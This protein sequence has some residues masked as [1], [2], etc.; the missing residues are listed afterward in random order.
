MVEQVAGQMVTGPCAEMKSG[1]P[2][3]TADYEDGA[4]YGQSKLANL[5]FARYKLTFL[6]SQL[7]FL[8]LKL[9]FLSSQLTFLSCCTPGLPL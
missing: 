7:T 8:S 3:P 6:S 1:V 4:A 9:T 5:L 2:V